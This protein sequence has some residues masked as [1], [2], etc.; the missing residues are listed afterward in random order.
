M[1]IV[2]AV[3]VGIALLCS[4]SGVRADE[5]G[6]E[7]SERCLEICNFDF[8]KCSER[9]G[10]KGHGRC[11]TDVVRCKKACPFATVEEPAVPTVKSHQRCVDRCRETY[12]K[13]LGQAKNKRGGNCAAD[14]MRC[15]RACPAPPEVAAVSPD[16]PGADGTAAGAPA[17]KAP[18]KSK[19]RRAARVEGAAAPAPAP[20]APPVV[21]RVEAPSPP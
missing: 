8:E 1:R 20:P 10:S 13:C 19:P 9:E 16:A 2:G 14:D 3:V 21:E 5:A 7:R 4:A 11:N 15:E 17:V 18:P 6:R 12:K